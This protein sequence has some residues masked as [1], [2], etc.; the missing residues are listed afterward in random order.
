MSQSPTEVDVLRSL[1]EELARQEARQDV[2]IGQLM[3]VAGVAAPIVVAASAA[4]GAL[5][6]LARWYLLLPVLPLLFSSVPFL[7]CVLVLLNQAIRGHFTGEEG[8]G[9]RTEPDPPEKIR[10]FAHVAG[11][12]MATMLWKRRAWMLKSV[13]RKFVIIDRAALWLTRGFA[14]L[15]SSL[16]VLLVLFLYLQLR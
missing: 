3:S 5:A 1:C 15:I 10:H 8:S 11:P 13:E 4:L 9:Q 7:A 12:Y 2:K 6:P 16:L 14:M